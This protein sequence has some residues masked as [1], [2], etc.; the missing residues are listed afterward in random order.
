MAPRAES[1]TRV[2][3]FRYGEGEMR[4]SFTALDPV[5]P[6]PPLDGGPFWTEEYLCDDFDLAVA[7]YEECAELEL[8]LSP[9]LDCKEGIEVLDQWFPQGI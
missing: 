4:Y 2:T 8:L 6:K 9:L 7:V 3:T 5:Q 1:E